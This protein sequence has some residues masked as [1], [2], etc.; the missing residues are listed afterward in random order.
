MHVLIF[1]RSYIIVQNFIQN[2]NKCECL[3]LFARRNFCLLMIIVVFDAF[4]P[5]KILTKIFVGCH[6]GLLPHIPI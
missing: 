2:V 1:S 5:I 6:L 3:Y 4:F